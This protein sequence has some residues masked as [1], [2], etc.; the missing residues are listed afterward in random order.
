MNRGLSVRTKIDK[1]RKE[2]EIFPINIHGIDGFVVFPYC[3]ERFSSLIYLAESKLPILIFIEENNFSYA[4]D[5]YEYLA[6]HENVEIAHNL[7]EV[8]E[9]D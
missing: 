3:T 5:T 4:L 2:D 6:E 9:K 1:R 7:E 8:E